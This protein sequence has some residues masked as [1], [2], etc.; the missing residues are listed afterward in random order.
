M[1]NITAKIDDMCHTVLAILPL[2]YDP[3]NTN[4]RFNIAL[5]I[6]NF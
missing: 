4:V 1:L 2:I 3:L 6:F 5:A